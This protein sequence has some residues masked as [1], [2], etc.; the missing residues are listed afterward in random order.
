MRMLLLCALLLCLKYFNASA[1]PQGASIIILGNI[2][3]EQKQLFSQ[4]IADE[5]HQYA[6]TI[7]THEPSHIYVYPY[8][9][10]EVWTVITLHVEGF[11]HQEK[12]ISLDLN[13]RPLNNLD[14]I[15]AVVGLD[16]S[17]KYI[18]WNSYN[19]L[20]PEK[21]LLA[22]KAIAQDYLFLHF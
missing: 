10:Q 15:R 4:T 22:S 12:I 5:I 18:S 21:I 20:P 11:Q 9:V 17:L 8:Q 1:Q 19:S 13:N 16:R 6:Q 2:N 14:E 7:S 3:D